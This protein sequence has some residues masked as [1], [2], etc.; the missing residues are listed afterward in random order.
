MDPDKITVELQHKARVRKEIFIAVGIAFVLSGDES[1]GIDWF[2]NISGYWAWLCLLLLHIYLAVMWSAYRWEL[3]GKRRLKCSIKLTGLSVLANSLW[4]RF[5]PQVT[6]E[7]GYT[8]EQFQDNADNWASAKQ[9]IRQNARKD[10]GFFMTNWFPEW[11]LYFGF[12]IVIRQVWLTSGWQPSG[13][14]SFVQ[15]IQSLAL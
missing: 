5:F 3:E 14:L 7:T 15:T 6:K 12:Y 11:V 9:S 10:L 4:N 8:R 1:P 2:V 13:L